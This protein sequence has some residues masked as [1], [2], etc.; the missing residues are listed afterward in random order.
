MNITNGCEMIYHTQQINDIGFIPEIILDDM[1]EVNATAT[2]QFPF[3][4]S[5]IINNILTFFF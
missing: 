5:I 4:V 3:H 2:F 1:V